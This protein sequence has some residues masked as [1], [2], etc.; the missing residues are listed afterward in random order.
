MTNFFVFGGKADNQKL[1]NTELGLTDKAGQFMDGEKPGE[2]VDNVDKKNQ[3]NEPEEL[4]DRSAV[5]E[6]FDNPGKKI[7]RKHGKKSRDKADKKPE[8][9][10][11]AVT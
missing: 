3:T 4:G 1:V 5:F 8:E 6:E 2:V 7:N 11:G 10:S 9:E